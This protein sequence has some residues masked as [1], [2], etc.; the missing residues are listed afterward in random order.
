M[1]SSVSRVQTCARS[2]EHTSELQS[3]D[4]LV[5]RLL[6]ENNNHHSPHHIAENPVGRE[7]LTIF[8]RDRPS[9]NGVPALALPTRRFFFLIKRGPP[10]SPLFPY[11]A[12]FR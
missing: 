2:E 4:N 3:H 7:H 9:G 11:P 10:R 5:C 12:L 1:P 8:L 6:L